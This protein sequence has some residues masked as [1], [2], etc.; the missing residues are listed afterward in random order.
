MSGVEIGRQ[1]EIVV[2]VELVNLRPVIVNADF[3]HLEFAALEVFVKLLNFRHFVNAARTPR[4]PEIHKYDF[5]AVIAKLDQPAALI[6]Y[7]EFGRFLSDIDDAG[8]ARVL[9]LPID[10][11]TSY[12]T[13]YYKEDNGFYSLAHGDLLYHL[14]PHL[15]LPGMNLPFEF[16]HRH[17]ALT[18]HDIVKLP[19]V[20]PGP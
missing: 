20:E 2:F 5:A 13:D 7:G 15:L 8:I 10:K 16:I 14:C 12:Q 4:S 17:G 18:E 6:F 11:T 19:Y 1:G 9:C 3:E